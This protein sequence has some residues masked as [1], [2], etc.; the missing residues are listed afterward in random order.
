MQIFHQWSWITVSVSILAGLLVVPAH[1]RQTTVTGGAN[2]SY[3]FR[4]RSYKENTSG[5]NSDEG[6]AKKVGIGPEVSVVSKD[7][8]DTLSFRY[9]PT[10]YYDYISE[11]NGVDHN[12]NLKGER[13]LSPFWSLTVTDDFIRSDDP[14]VSSSSSNNTPYSAGGGQTP[15]PTADQLSRDLS[16]QTYWTNTA[17]VQTAY[18]LSALSSIGGGYSYSVLRN[19]QGSG[20]YTSQQDAQDYDDYDKH[21]FFTNYS[22]GF[23]QNWRSSL[24]LNYTRGL[25]DEAPVGTGNSVGNPDLDQYGGNVGV[26]YIQDPNNFFPLK[27]SY[28]ETQYDGD[29]RPGYQA[30]NGSIG[31]DHAFDP[32]TRL[33]VGAG[34][35]FAKTDGLDGTWG[36]NGYLSFSRKYE[37]AA[38]A[39]MLDKQY[40]AQNFTGTED[41]GLTDTYSATATLTYQYTERL[42]LDVHGRYSWEST[43]SPQG[44]YLAAANGG[45]PSGN[46]TGDTAYDT[47]TYEAGAGCSYS[48][49]QWYRAGVKY[50]YYVSDGNLASDQYTDHQ[51]LF[52]LSAAKELWRW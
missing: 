35:S 13:A 5:T 30:H 7:I 46:T 38:F 39:L 6:D 15:A 28:S 52:T 21:A 31:W 4:S 10:L 29:T 33:A 17:T 26:D 22:H 51:V 8:Y 41:S 18:T 32:R 9:A 1:A 12:L 34:P 25:Y 23:N 3:D 27:Y 42:A 20:G 49:A 36:Y 48:F 50:T 45:N 37:H 19:D 2:T 40:A 16:G 47:N 24:G 43:F 11:D 14:S 44:D